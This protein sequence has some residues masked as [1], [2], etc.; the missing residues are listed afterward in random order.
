MWKAE[1][2]MYELRYRSSLGC[3]KIVFKLQNVNVNKRFA[4]EILKNVP[5]SVGR[6]DF[7][8]PVEYSEYI[9]LGHISREFFTIDAQ[10]KVQV[11]PNNKTHFQFQDADGQILCTDNLI[12]QDG[13]VLIVANYE[14]RDG[15][16]VGKRLSAKTPLEY[17]IFI[18]TPD[19][20][21]F[22]QDDLVTGKKKRKL[23]PKECPN[24]GKEYLN[25]KLHMNFC[26]DLQYQKLIREA[27]KNKT[28]VMKKRTFN[29]EQ[30]RKE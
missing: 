21:G 8:H 28:F 15:Q 9:E 30:R 18:E 23:E 14:E 24:C 13:F 19:D 20:L 27:G 2:N 4:C 7:E 6:S 5:A 22:D 26:K 17:R 12:L 16:I 1:A 25:L 11:Y 3:S 10:Y 29:K